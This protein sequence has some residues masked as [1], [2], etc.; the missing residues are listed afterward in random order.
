MRY[1]VCVPAQGV[2]SAPP[3]ADV[4]GAAFIPAMVEMPHQGSITFFNSD[5]LFAYGF[6]A[7]ITLWLFGM[8]VGFILSLVRSHD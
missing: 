2:P 4:D 8:A 5:T 7:V 3:C 6:T 1:V